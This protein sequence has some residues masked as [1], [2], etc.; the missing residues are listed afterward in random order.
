[1]QDDKSGVFLR[2]I[3][4]YI[5]EVKVECYETSCA[6]EAGRRNRGIRFARKT[7]IR[8]GRRVVAGGVK[9]R[10]GSR[11]DILIEF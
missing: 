4:Q 11:I 7:F 9:D 2:R 5:R 10:N 1:M 3:H 6:G 8:H